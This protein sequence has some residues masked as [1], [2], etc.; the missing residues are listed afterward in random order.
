MLNNI[1]CGIKRS[2]DETDTNT[3]IDPL[4]RSRF[5]LTDAEAIEDLLLI[6]HNITKQNSHHEQ[7]KINRRKELNRIK[8]I[9]WRKLIL[10]KQKKKKARNNQY[11]IIKKA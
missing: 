5:S 9:N 1:S 11:S 7:N 4:K 2:W 8:R 3:S 6:R 10:M